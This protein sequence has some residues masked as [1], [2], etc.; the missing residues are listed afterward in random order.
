MNCHELAEHKL[1]DEAEGQQ[2]M[3]VTITQ[4][5][6]GGPGRS[7]C[8]LTNIPPPKTDTLVDVVRCIKMD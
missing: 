1:S 8:H 3:T 7:V 5:D 4:T 2:V 6:L